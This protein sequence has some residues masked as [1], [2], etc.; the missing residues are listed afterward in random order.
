MRVLGAE[1]RSFEQPLLHALGAADLEVVSDASADASADGVIGFGSESGADVL[2][3]IH[4]LCGSSAERET[5]LDL[6]VVTHGIQSVSQDEEHPE[7]AAIPALV[8]T[9]AR[10]LPWLRP[11]HVDL[12]RDT[13]DDELVSQL[14]AELGADDPEVAWRRGRRWVP[15]LD[16]IAMDGAFADPVRPGGSYLITGGGGGIGRELA[17]YLLNIGAS[18][19]LLGRRSSQDPELAEQLSELRRTGPVVYESVDVTDAEA[20]LGA[21]ELAE[22]TLDA[23]IEGIFHLAGVAHERLLSMESAEGLAEALAPKLDGARAVCEAL[24]DRDIFFVALSSVVA[25]VPGAGAGAY[26]AANRS[27][28]AFCRQLQAH[29]TAPVRVVA[30]SAWRGVGLNADLRSDEPARASGFEVLSKTQGMRSLIAALCSPDADVEPVLVGLDAHHPQ[31]VRRLDRAP[32]LRT[33]PSVLYEAGA[34]LRERLGG[35]DVE[36]RSVEALPR[37]DD[38]TVDGSRLASLSRS[39]TTAVLQTDQQRRVAALFEDVLGVEGVGPADNF[40]RLGGHS[41]SAMQLLTRLRESEGVVIEPARFLEGPTVAQLAEAWAESEPET[42]DRLEPIEPDGEKRFEPF[43]LTEIQQAYW[44]G[45]SAEFE[46][47]DV[48]MHLYAEVDMQADGTDRVDVERLNRAWNGVVARHD[49]LRAV[50]AED[51]TERVSDRVPD[52]RIA[53]LELG[54]LPEDGRRIALEAQ[55]RELSHQQLAPDQWPGFEIRLA[56]LGAGRARLFI[57]MAA[58]HLD[59]SSFLLVMSE[60][61]RRYRDSAF[62]PPPLTLAY[63]DYALALRQVEAEHT[64]SLDYWRERLPSLPPAPALPMVREPAMLKNYR[65]RHRSFRLSPERWQAIKDVAAKKGI[66]RSA[67]GMAAFAAVLDMWSRSSLGLT[68]NVTIFNR[69]PLHAEVQQITGDFTSMVLLGTQRDGDDS[70][71]SFARR[72]QEQLWRDLAHRY[73]SGVTVMRELARIRKQPSKALMPVVFTSALD[74]ELGDVTSPYSALRDLGDLGYQMS[75]TPQVMFDCQLFE[76]AGSLLCMWDTIDEAFPEG[77]LDAMLGA[78]HGVMDALADEAQW[79][80]WP[81]VPETQLAARTVANATDAPVSDA[82]LHTL[83]D[84]QAESHPERPAL[85]TDDVTVSYGELA[86]KARKVG[87]W[88]R[89]VGARPDELVAVV[90]DKGVDQV[91]GVLGVLYSGAAYLPIDPKLPPKRRDHLM[92]AGKVRLAVTDTAGL[93]LQWPDGVEAVD[94]D[95]PGVE[96]LSDAPLEPVQGPGQPGLCDFHLRLHGPAPRAWPSSTGARSIRFWTSISASVWDPRIAPSPF[97]P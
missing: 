36:L 32:A 65:F 41:M 44:I 97:R 12:D 82:L 31:I 49:M 85:I 88:L 58:V 14:V 47:G 55:R 52:Y 57:S 25:A 22:E 26:A 90:M 54:R 6:W 62:D 42:G 94:V 64:E 23:E 33:R 38:G 35:L 11:R 13:S 51:G 9:A 91:V 4:E 59:G 95:G 56:H 68:L 53:E 89:Q 78:M 93:E 39:A 3:L 43:P 8:A 37:H 5:P 34:E 48:S 67:V 21:V 50:I 73:V 75:Q 46:L 1:G 69:L 79:Q 70:F 74:L 2:A 10:E 17:R 72:T 61:G 84:R 24:S 81:R 63:R 76:E 16:R 45:R 20:V 86:S 27:L 77:M 87:A 40:F 83:F 66:S 18:V 29:R 19:L 15:G 30:F 96:A 92:A 71:E 60:W 28:E 80:Q 7:A